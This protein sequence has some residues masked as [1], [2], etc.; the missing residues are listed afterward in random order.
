MYFSSIPSSQE[1]S[2]KQE[3]AAKERRRILS[4]GTSTNISCKRSSLN[5]IHSRR[6]RL[7]SSPSIPDRRFSSYLQRIQ[8]TLYNGNDVGEDYAKRSKSY[9]F[10]PEETSTDTGTKPTFRS[11]G[12]RHK[13][14]SDHVR[15]VNSKQENGVREAVKKVERGRDVALG[16]TQ[17]IKPDQSDLAQEFEKCD[18]EFLPATIIESTIISDELDSMGSLLE[19]NVPE[20]TDLYSDSLSPHNLNHDDE[21][22][23]MIVCSPTRTF[24]TNEDVDVISVD[25][26]TIDEEDVKISNTNS[27]TNGLLGDKILDETDFEEKLTNGIHEKS[28]K[29]EE[30]IKEEFL[31][32]KECKPD[33]ID[34]VGSIGLE[35]EIF[36][37]VR[38]DLG[39]NQHF[40]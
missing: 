8:H 6:S 22:K 7:K 24:K 37:K 4:D 34:D 39:I 5:T 31:E 2:L 30:K 15:V 40:N 20:K 23:S 17:E 36:T 14:R 38:L 12:T 29:L 28:P 10:V 32:K 13:L 33:V 25:R 3:P 35:D 19:N 27:L 18:S 11:A 1:E 21:L 26:K 9:D 16:Y